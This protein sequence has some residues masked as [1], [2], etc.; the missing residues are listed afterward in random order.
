MYE[1]LF[2]K[3]KKALDFIRE[4]ED[5]VDNELNSLLPLACTNLR[6]KTIVGIAEMMTSFAEHQRIARFHN[7]INNKSAIHQNNNGCMFRQIQIQDC[8][9]AIGVSGSDYLAYSFGRFIDDKIEILKANA[10][11][12][13][14]KIQE[15][16]EMLA[17]LFDASIIR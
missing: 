9:F 14:V 2:K 15:E 12:D 13:T 10:S 6:S 11:S 1:D 16:I 4:T 8:D 5:I 3:N 7:A 17:K